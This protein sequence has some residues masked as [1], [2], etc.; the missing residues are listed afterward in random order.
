LRREQQEIKSHRGF[1]YLK[2]LHFWS[3]QVW[4]GWAL[5]TLSCRCNAYWSLHFLFGLCKRNGEKKNATEKPSALETDPAERVSIK[6]MPM[7]CLQSHVCTYVFRLD[8][9]CAN[10]GA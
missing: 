3:A 7:M 1:P 8:A 5:S 4:S 9:F 10:F 6:I 2:K